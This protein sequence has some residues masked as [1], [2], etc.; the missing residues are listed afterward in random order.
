[1]SLAQKHKAKEC[2]GECH[3]CRAEKNAGIPTANWAVVTGESTRNKRR[4]MLRDE[5]ETFNE[6]SK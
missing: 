2:G 1:M 6:E 3:Y 5:I 4:K